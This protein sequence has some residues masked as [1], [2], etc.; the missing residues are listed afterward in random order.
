MARIINDDQ[1]GQ[2][3]SSAE[4]HLTV[5]K[6]DGQTHITLPEGDFMGKGDIL[7][8]GQDL[9]LQSSD[10][11]EVVIEGYFSAMP[12]PTLTTPHG[13]MLTPE[14]VQSFVKSDGPVEL[15]ANESGSDASAVGIIKEVS[16]DATITRTD[17]T[18]EKITL[19]M[20]VHQ[21]DI[22]E[23]SA[24]G[25]VNVVFL[26]ES[27]FTVSNNARLAIDEYVFDPATQSGE[28]NVSILR[29]MFV[30]TSGLIGRDDPDDVQIETPIGSIGIRGTTIAGHINPDGESQITVVEGAIVIKNG[31]GETTLDEQYETVTLT[32]YEA[33]VQMEGTLDAHQMKDSYGMLGTVN[34]GFFNTLNTEPADNAPEDGAVDDGTLNDGAPGDEPA[35]ETAPGET[36]ADAT[37]PVINPLTEPTTEPTTEGQLVAE[38]PV[39]A[40]YDT[41]SDPLNT[42]FDTSVAPKLA[43]PYAATGTTSITGTTSTTTTLLSPLP[44]PPPPS[45]T[46]TTTTTANGTTTTTTTT[47]TALPPLGLVVEVFVDDDAISGEVVGRAFTTLAFPDVQMQFVRVPLDGNGDPLFAL[48]AEAPGVYKIVLTDAGETA[49]SAATLNSILGAVDVLA[50]L[51]DGR[52]TIS[53]APAHYG[54][55][56]NTAVG[57]STP[58]LNLNGINGA[59]GYS[60]V[61]N[62]GGGYSSAYLGDFDHDGTNNFAAATDALTGSVFISGLASITKAGDSSDMKI[63][64]GGDVNGDGKLD[65]VTGRAYNDVAAT[66]AG[67][68]NIH[69]GNNPSTSFSTTYGAAGSDLFGSSVAMVDFNGDGYVD[70]FAGAKFAGATPAEG[71]LLKFSGS[72]G[73]AFTGAP[74]SAFAA[75]GAISSQLGLSMTGLGDYNG[76]GFGD[77]AVGG[78]G[79]VKI[80]MGNAAGN[81]GTVFQIAAPI[82][83]GTFN[84][85]VFDLGDVNG[86]GR[87]DLMIGATGYNSNAGAALISFGNN[88]S[89]TVNLTIQATAGEKI[90]GGGSAGDFNGD[91]FD[92]MFVATRNGDIVDGY[93]IYGG[94]GLGGAITLDPTWMANNPGAG[95]HMTLDL[96]PLLADPVNDGIDL[97]ATSIGDQNGDGFEDML[98]SSAQIN[99]GAGGYYVVNGRPDPLDL[100]AGNPDVHAVGINAP[101]LGA[102]AS[103]AGDGLV[104][105]GAN[106]TLS[107]NN[108]GNIYNQISF[109]AGAGND[110]I[111]LYGTSN[112]MTRVVDGGANRDELQ[113][114]TTG[115]IDLRSVSEMAGIEE[116]VF[117]GAASQS[118]IIGLNDIF[119]LMQSSSEAL[120]A[121]GGGALSARYTL[122]ITNDGTGT[123]DLTIDNPNSSGLTMATSGFTQNG[124][125]NDGGGNTYDIYTSGTGYQVLIEQTVTVNVV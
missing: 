61:L 74:F 12:S 49:I 108:S 115:T 42:G 109:Q 22:I 5:M 84:M 56:S 91:G 43:D 17:G 38:P 100:A 76:D 103:S 82:D 88:S 86:D 23:T 18:S 63:A 30:F 54:D 96:N 107:N 69:S 34:A 77:V 120:D 68:V 79:F 2:S 66:D 10:G 112:N 117:T 80:Y 46:T 90:V 20:A 19:G 101:P 50:R 64:G 73:F 122:M 15:A 89:G 27:S 83:T 11:H 95:F 35:A 25:A 37:D 26:D 21:G 40:S 118:L 24:Q 8:D 7:R 114:F 98:L 65:F 57:G 111:Q 60:V 116:I 87:S 6:V 45:S 13:S 70:I 1:S 47:T 104:G 97:T 94:T 36:P 92:D 9:V 3:G 51:P 75:G 31:T 29:G 16:G 44:P 110:I 41:F 81:A 121:D 119:S 4:G 48:V 99:N 72:S 52:E 105:D 55:F 62:N 33:P 123:K 14:L 106:N 71:E 28:T 125:Y 39:L 53:T 32:G 85:P 124:T 58:P 78:N 102:V 67:Q 93:V 113:L 59:E